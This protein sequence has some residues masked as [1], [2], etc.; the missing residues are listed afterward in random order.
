MKVFH[1]SDDLQR[2]LRDRRTNNR[3]V[4]FVPT[5]GA[6]HQGHLSLVEQSRQDNQLTVVSIF[7]N[8]TQFN[9]PEDLQK[10][11]RTPGRDIEFLAS[12]GCEVVFL[13]TVEQVYPPDLPAP[14]PLGFGTLATVME[15][16]MRP[17]HFDGVA[18]VVHR[19]LMLTRPDVL[20]LGQKDYQQVAI[21]RSMIDQRKVPVAVKMAPT[22]RE[23]DGLAM[24]SRNQRL[25]PAFRRKAPEIYRLLDQCKAE[26]LEGESPQR[27]AKRYLD[28]LAAIPGFQPEYLDL[29]D[30]DTLL[31]LHDLDAAE[32]AVVATAVWAGDVRLIDNVIIK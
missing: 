17:G 28:L 18:Q 16:A 5:M 21:V 8:P 20:Y 30:G 15:G 2:Y 27:V 13:P 22:V 7:V 12:V 10:Y 11:P 19:L 6:L 31:P 4:G 24:S 25:T 32:R 14:S 3:T 29:V 9:D 26:V 23:E 1:R